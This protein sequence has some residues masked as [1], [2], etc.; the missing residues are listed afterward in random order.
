MVRGGR[1]QVCHLDSQKVFN[2]V[3][4]GLFDQKSKPFGANAKANNWL[5]QILNGGSLNVRVTDG[6]PHGSMLGSL[7]PLMYV[8]A[9][10]GWW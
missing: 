4:H 10:F 2:Y 1:V 9:S 6:V 8:T 5:A 3:N 7:P